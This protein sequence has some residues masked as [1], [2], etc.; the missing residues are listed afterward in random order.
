MGNLFIAFYGRKYSKSG[1]NIIILG[2]L[3][4]IDKL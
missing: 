1:K 2:K 3:I 4:N